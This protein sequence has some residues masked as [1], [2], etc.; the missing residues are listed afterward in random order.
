MSKAKK[1]IS[2][3]TGNVVREYYAIRNPKKVMVLAMYKISRPDKKLRKS[4]KAI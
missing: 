4:K 1:Y 3:K 2:R